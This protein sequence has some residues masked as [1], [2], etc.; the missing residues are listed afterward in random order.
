MT[1]RPFIH[2]SLALLLAITLL[3]GCGGQKRPADMPPLYPCTITVTQDGQPLDGGMVTL[4]ST[5]PS[6]KWVVFAQLDS[7]GTGKLFTQGLYA[8][9]PA[10]EYQVVLSKEEVVSEQAGQ[11]V[12][13][14]GEFGEE[15][16]TPFIET[17][18]SLVEKKYTDVG[19]TPLSMTIARKGNDPKFD[20]GKPVREMLRRVTP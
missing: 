8:G 11:T 18:F 9:A 20:C 10:G 15:S 3:P 1:F 5:D 4:A 16:F 14:Q 19:T 13:R 2:T 17:V 7:S 6:F 12:V